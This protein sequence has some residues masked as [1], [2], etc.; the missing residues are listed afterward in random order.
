MNPSL[1]PSPFSQLQV[2]FRCLHPHVHHVSSSVCHC[3]LTCLHQ[4]RQHHLSVLHAFLQA[5]FNFAFHMY[6]FPFCKVV[7]LS[8]LFIVCFSAVPARPAAKQLN[9]SLALVGICSFCSYLKLKDERIF[10]SHK[11]RKDWFLAKCAS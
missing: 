2:Q 3:C 4:Q 6:D 11:E 9:N 7:L 10:F 1:T 5:A 8:H